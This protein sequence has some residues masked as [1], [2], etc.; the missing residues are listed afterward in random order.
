[1]KEQNKTMQAF[2]AIDEHTQVATAWFVQCD[3]SD[4]LAIVIRENATAPWEFKIRSRYYMDD[5]VFDSKDRKQHYTVTGGK[6][7]DASRD[8]LVEAGRKICDDIANGL[9]GK[10]WTIVVNGTGEAFIERYK[11]LPM[12]HWKEQPSVPHESPK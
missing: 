12:V 10:L 1:M 5:K 9:N 2:I 11:E 8:D 4:V 7:T 6:P 3:G